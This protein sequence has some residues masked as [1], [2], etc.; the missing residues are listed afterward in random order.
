MMSNEDRIVERDWDKLRMDVNNAIDGLEDD[1]ERDHPDLTDEEM[2]DLNNRY[3]GL[4][5][6]L[7]LFCGGVEAMVPNFIEKASEEVFH[8]EL[9]QVEGGSS[10]IH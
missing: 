6:L 8:D 10:K 2:E 4:I 3:T 5:K 1:W 9:F 7:A